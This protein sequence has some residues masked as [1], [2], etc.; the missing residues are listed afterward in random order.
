M[1]ETLVG[2]RV[3]LSSNVET[4]MTERGMLQQQQCRACAVY[5]CDK[6]Q[7]NPEYF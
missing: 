5:V 2:L 4:K 1:Y 7:V 6:K 3:S